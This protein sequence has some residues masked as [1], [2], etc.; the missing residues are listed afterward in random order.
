M[1]YVRAVVLFVILA[2]GRN[3][4]MALN[5]DDAVVTALPKDARLVSD[6]LQAALA[7]KSGQFRN[8]AWPR[9][10]DNARVDSSRVPR[11]V[12]AK[13]SGWLATMIRAT[14]LPKDPNNW[15][16]PIRKP[17]PGSYLH[18]KMPDG[19]T[20]KTHFPDKGFD[21]Y[22]ISSYSVRGHKFQIQENDVA[23]HLLIDVSDTKLFSS[24]I[25]QFVT[26]AL[27]EF[28]NYPLDHKAALDFKLE[29]FKYGSQTVWFGIVNCDFDM[30]D[31]E[32]WSK[33][34]WWNHTFV[35]T[36]GK[37]IYLSMAER[38]GRPREPTQAKPGIPPRF[39]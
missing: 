9:D 5:G 34:T 13:T 26:N 11:E 39:K 7:E 3:P 35:W 30:Q 38:D 6:E 28:L 23:V 12:L 24:H 27:Y 14:Y 17:R 20:R 29:N 33:R 31:N 1:K 19:T 21:D 18:E 10:I 2:V 36:D 37:R 8:T 16:I 32:A 4:A 25:E 15:L 22:L